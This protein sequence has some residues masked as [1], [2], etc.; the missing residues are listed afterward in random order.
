[1]PKGYIPPHHKN[2]VWNV[3]D[4]LFHPGMGLLYGG[5][6]A[7]NLLNWSRETLY[8][9]ADEMDLTVVRRNRLHGGRYFLVNE[10]HALVK[11]RSIQVSVD[12][13][14]RI[15]IPKSR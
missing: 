14:G 13:K 2:E 3:P 6:M 11:K 15:K 4:S 12:S 7:A 5:K 8:R 10:I 9:K 1:M